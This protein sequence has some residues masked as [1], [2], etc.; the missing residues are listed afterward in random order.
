L[1]IDS[2]AISFPSRKN[3]IVNNTITI[4]DEHASQARTNI[5]EANALKPQLETK[6]LIVYV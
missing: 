6:T 2:I 5:E 3:I 1:N 4:S